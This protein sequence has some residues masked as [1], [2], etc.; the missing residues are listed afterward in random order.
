MTPVRQCTKATDPNID[1]LEANEVLKSSKKG[2]LP[3]VS[4]E[5]NLVALIARQDLLKNEEFPL[6]T[7]AADKSLMVAAAV[8]T[9]P[10]DKD[11][12][13][14][15]VAA[16]VDMIVVDSSQGDSTFQKEMLT[17]IKKEFPRVDL[18][19]GNVVTRLQA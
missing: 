4:A 18:V 17:W 10:Q 8:G 12:A 15:L 1:L 6:A 7:K 16:G 2:K 5:G 19:G 13:R 3:I 9:R 14:A 11:R